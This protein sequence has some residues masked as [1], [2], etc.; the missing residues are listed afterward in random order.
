LRFYETCL[1]LRPTFSPEEA[2]KVM[3]RI[4]NIIRESG[5]EITKVDSWGKRKLAY[6][7]DKEKEGLYYFLHFSQNPGGI[8]EIKRQLKLMP[9]VLRFMV[10]KLEHG[11]KDA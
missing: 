8:S 9:E 1:I 5:G 2:D 10:L 11:G 6:T 4:Q 3:E 7:I